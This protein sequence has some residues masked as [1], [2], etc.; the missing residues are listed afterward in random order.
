M[1]DVHNPATGREAVLMPER[2]GEM[3]RSGIVRSLTESVRPNGASG[4]D[5]DELT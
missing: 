3:I 5:E 2:P 4:R 1:R